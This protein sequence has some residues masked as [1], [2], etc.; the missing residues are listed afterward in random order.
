MRQPGRPIRVVLGDD[1]AIV[2]EGLRALLEAVGGFDVVAEAKDGNEAVAAAERT[3]PDVVVLDLSMPAMSGLE[4]LRRIKESCRGVR[5]LVLSMHATSEY[6]RAALRSGADGYLVKGTGIDDLREA[7]LRVTAGERYVCA[8][9]ERAALQ[10]IL[11]GPGI[12]ASADPL[13]RLTSRERE[14]L[15]LIAE[16]HSNR[17]I[18]DKLGLSIKTVDGHRTK[19]MSKLDLHDATALTRFAIRHG[20]VSPDQ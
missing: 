5:V 7:P 15:Q 17:A 11:D 14:V 4:A 13:D 1:H 3:R 19:V 16:G 10:D 6:A 2:R 8:E 9:V 18:A 20:L 12:E